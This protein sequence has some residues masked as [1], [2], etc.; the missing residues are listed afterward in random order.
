MEKRN[1]E[2]WDGVKL[3][4]L[5]VE[6]MAVRKEM[7]NV[8]ATRL[9]EKWQNVEAKV[10]TQNNSFENARCDSSH[11]S[12][13]CMEKGIKNISAAYKSA[14]RKERGMVTQRHPDPD[15]QHDSGFGG[16][17]T[18]AEY[19]LDLAPAMTTTVGESSGYIAHIAP[20]API[21]HQQPQ[22]NLVPLQPLPSQPMM[23]GG[24]T[25]HPSSHG[26]N[27]SIHAMLSPSPPAEEDEE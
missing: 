6:Y 2:D 15:H 19:E 23:L 3:E 14:M 4:K 27:M 24:R 11:Q 25:M 10:R 5:A 12:T 16:S 18:D 9:N 7:W 22:Y 1:A 13:Q 20:R 17:D 26:R 21:M 8:L